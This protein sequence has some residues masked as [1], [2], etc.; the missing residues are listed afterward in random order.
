MVFYSWPLIFS[1]L[2]GYIMDWIDLIIIRH[3]FAFAE[4]GIYQ[5]AYRIFFLLSNSLSA[6]TT[7]FFPV[8][9]ATLLQGK[10]KL[11]KDF[12]IGRLIPQ[13]TLLWGLWFLYY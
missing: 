6:I 9:V 4:V 1:L 13:V 12:Y 10:N 8:L 3:Y 7:V 5:A 2:S 11:I